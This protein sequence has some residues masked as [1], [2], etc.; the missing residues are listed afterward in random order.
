[1]HERKMLTCKRCGWSW[2]PRKKE[3]VR[4]CAKCKSAYWDEEKTE[5]KD[6]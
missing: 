2:F 4:Q 5:K 6:S 1:M 3:N